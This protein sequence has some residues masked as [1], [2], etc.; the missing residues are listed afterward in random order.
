M[1]RWQPQKLF[2]KTTNELQNKPKSPVNLTNS[3]R[4]L[5]SS[6][7]ATPTFHPILST[8]SLSRRNPRR[9]FTLVFL[10]AQWSIGLQLHLAIG[11]S[12][13]KLSSVGPP[14][15]PDSWLCYDW[16]SPCLFLPPDSSPPVWIPVQCS[17]L[18]CCQIV[19]VSCIQQSP[20]FSS[21]RPVWWGA[22]LFSPTDWCWIS[23]QAFWH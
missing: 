15:F 13:G 3:T 9:L 19:C 14:S 12:L 4:Q 20:T 5:L 10:L 17:A 11:L 1:M 23:C 8:G 18:W 21:S 16:P 2:E 6:T 22:G 7:K